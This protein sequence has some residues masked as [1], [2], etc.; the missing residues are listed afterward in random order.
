M[1]QITVRGVVIISILEFIKKRFILT[2]ITKNP[3]NPLYERGDLNSPP[4]GWIWIETFSPS[5]S[6]CSQAMQT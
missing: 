4:W 5:S 6:D 2:T 1:V 3:P